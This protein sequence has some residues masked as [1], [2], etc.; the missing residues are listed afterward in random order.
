MT[1]ISGISGD[2]LKKGASLRDA[3]DSAHASK[4]ASSIPVIREHVYPLEKVHEWFHGPECAKVEINK[5][6][7]AT[8]K[9]KLFT[10]PNGS[11]LHLSCEHR[12]RYCPKKELAESYMESEQ[13]RL[14]MLSDPTLKFN[15]KTAQECI[16]D[17]IFECK[18]LECICPVC[19]GFRFKQKA[20]D[21]MRTEARKTEVCI[22]PQCQE[23]T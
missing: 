14:I 16:C 15:V 21:L 20:W 7:K 18:V 5:Q 17:C 11:V 6:S 22:C 3:N 10:L 8:Y 19:T 13:H 12:I 23:G 2:V 9:R 1:R 4:A